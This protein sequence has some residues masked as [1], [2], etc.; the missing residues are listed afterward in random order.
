MR[1][2]VAMLYHKNHIKQ[3]DIVK[4]YYEN[5][6]LEVI[7]KECDFMSML[8]HDARN[9]FFATY[10]ATDWFLILDSDE[11]L[12]AED[13]DKLKKLMEDKDN[14]I[15]CSTII[16]YLGIDRIVPQR[17]HMPCI[18]VRNPVKYDLKY[19]FD[20]KRCLFNCD[21]YK[22]SNITLHHL[23]YIGDLQPKINS[24][25]NRRI[26]SEVAVVKRVMNSKGEYYK[27]PIVVNNII[28]QIVEGQ[29]QRQS[30]LLSFAPL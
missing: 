24:Y 25:M 23:G 29:C 30:V 27:A 4:K 6:G 16:D 12:L 19:Q 17:N 13:I 28:K 7:D 9:R 11:I 20:D 14:N 1:I 15:I 18:A 22:C 5:L 21:I 3:K 8:E 26:F 2:A 10:T